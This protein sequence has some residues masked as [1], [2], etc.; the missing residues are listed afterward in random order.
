MV[1]RDQTYVSSLGKRDECK[2]NNG[3]AIPG[4]LE[5]INNPIF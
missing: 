3:V 2:D 1:S 5:N 4:A